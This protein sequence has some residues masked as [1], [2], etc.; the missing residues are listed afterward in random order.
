MG[1]NGQ[2][3]DTHLVSNEQFGL[4]GTSSVRGYFQSEAVADNGVG[5]SFEIQ[6]PSLATVFGTFVDELRFFGFVDAGYTYLLGR[7]PTG[8][9]SDFTLVGA[10]GGLRIRLLGHLSGNVIAGVPLVAGPVSKK[11]DPRVTFQ[12]KSEF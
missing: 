8:Q 9:A 6:S 7:L 5:G 2:L 10:G 1:V 4:G 11:G 12:I 3:A